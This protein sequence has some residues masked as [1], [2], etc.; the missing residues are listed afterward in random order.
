MGLFFILLIFDVIGGL[1]ALVITYEEM[2]HRYTSRRTRLREVS[3][4]AFSAFIFLAALS[5]IVIL[6]LQRAMC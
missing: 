6:I 2:S 1:M 5:A 4:R 3:T